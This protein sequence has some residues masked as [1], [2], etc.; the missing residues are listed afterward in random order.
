MAIG[1]LIKKPIFKIDG[2]TLTVGLL[3]V[4]VILVYFFYLRKR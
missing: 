2:L 4:I 1:D 3:V